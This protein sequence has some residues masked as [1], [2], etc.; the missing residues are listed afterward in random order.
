VSLANGQAELLRDAL[1]AVVSSG[2]IAVLS[3]SGRLSALLGDLLYGQPQLATAL[4]TASSVGIT[5]SLA[6][7]I[8][9]GTETEQAVAVAASSLQWQTQLA[10]DV[11]ALVAAELA[12]ALS[13][14]P[15]SQATSI[16]MSRPS[17]RAPR[18]RTVWISVGVLAVVALVALLVNVLMGPRV[19]HVK[20]GAGALVVTPDGRTLYVADPGD[21]H[22]DNFQNGHTVTPVNV[23]T[24]IPGTPI[25]VGNHP[26]ALAVTPDGRILYVADSGNTV[27]PVNVASS[28]PGTPIKVRHGPV[29]MVVAPDGRTLYVLTTGYAGERGMVVPV[30]IATGTTGTPI[31]VGNVPAAMVMTPDGRTLY[32]ANYADSTVTPVAIATAKPGTAIPVGKGPGGLVVTPDG[33]TL[34]V[35][36]SGDPGLG[37]GDT[38]TPIT[39]ATDRPGAPIKV[40]SAPQALAVTPDGRTLYVA[41]TNSNTVTPVSVTTG[42]PGAPIKVGKQ[43]QALAVTPDGRTVYVANEIGDTVSV[44]SLKR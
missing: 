29:A 20:D 34:Y 25:K 32:V 5:R 30:N 7:L 24:G 28:T 13:L 12:R 27:T 6:N 31:S 4:V 40:G 17:L 11:C 10:P 15:A 18:R 16:A 33:Q 36:N 9:S 26:Q 41:N 43:P 14:A 2:G 44:I 19:I 8:R 38:V 37:G 39:I 1:A 35:T 21:F 22:G 3:D 42:S 23:A